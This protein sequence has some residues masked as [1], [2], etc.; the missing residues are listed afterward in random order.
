MTPKIFLWLLSDPFHDQKN[1]LSFLVWYGHYVV[2]RIWKTLK[3]WKNT[4]NQAKIWKFKL[5][6]YCRNFCGSAKIPSKIFFCPIFWP[7]KI[8]GRLDNFWRLKFEKSYPPQ[9]KNRDFWG[10]VGNLYDVYPR[11]DLRCERFFLE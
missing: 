7:K 3:F 10:E 2:L 1:F 8:L 4:K 6:K 9:K 5:A 11:H